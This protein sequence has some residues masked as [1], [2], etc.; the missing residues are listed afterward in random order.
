VRVSDEDVAVAGNVDAVGELGDEVGRDLAQE[1]SL[2]VDH[3]HRVT[4][5]TDVIHFSKW[6][7]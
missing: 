6:F 5:E 2:T 3:H 4:L 1:V 7:R